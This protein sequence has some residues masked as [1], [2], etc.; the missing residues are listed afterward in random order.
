MS[1]V[2]YSSLILPF[3]RAEAPGW[4]LLFR[5]GRVNALHHYDQWRDAP[6]R[7][8]LGKR[9]RF[10]MRL[11]L[12]NWSE[13]H[14]Y[15]LGRYYELATLLAL[16]AFLRPGDRMLDV[17]ANIGMVALEAARLVGPTG[18]VD[19]FEPNPRCLDRL[20]EHRS[21]NELEWLHIHPFA[22]ADEDSRQCLSVVTDHDGMGTLATVS[23]EDETLVSRRFEVT[24]RR[25]DDAV[26]AADGRDPA[27]IKIDVEGF[28]GRVLAGLQG[29][30]R[31]SHPVVYTEF[32]D[33]HLRRDGSSRAALFEFMSRQGYAGFG[34]S[35]RRRG[36]R[37]QLEL[38]PLADAAA[39]IE[40]RTADVLWTQ[41]G[42]E[43]GQPFLAT[44]AD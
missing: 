26:R 11:N 34:A 38:T 43:R 19:C 41:T 30:L 31:E 22:L 7:E 10:K 13:R 6:V 20:A 42:D 28:E 1:P 17:G 33:A 15:F 2:A 12:S 36:L 32:V 21:L 29:V 27:F 25:G 8:I 44:N 35:T 9:H 18:R 24:T 37:H 40:C 5:L 3:T 16:D 14:T 39:A 23:A 4:G